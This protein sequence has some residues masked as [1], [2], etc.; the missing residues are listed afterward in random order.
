MNFEPELRHYCRNPKCRMKLRKPVENRRDAFCTRGCHSSFY[1]RRCLICEDEMERKTGNQLV[2]G[3]R[4]CRNALWDQKALGRYHP[5]SGPYS[6]L[7]K[8]IK[9]GLKTGPQRRPTSL[10]ANA[11]L[12][13]LGEVGTLDQAVA[14]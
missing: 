14:S 9:P 11:P 2:C 10:F 13:L 12:N 3:K 8:S 4:R 6:D 7:E 5:T 1:R